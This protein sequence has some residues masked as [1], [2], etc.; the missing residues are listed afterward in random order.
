MTITYKK[1]I[2]IHFSRAIS[3]SKLCFTSSSILRRPKKEEILSDK[4][5]SEP[6]DDEEKKA[7]KSETKDTSDKE[8]DGDEEKKASPVKKDE[9]TSEKEEGKESD[10]EAADEKP[11]KTP[12]I[13]LKCP[14]CLIRCATFGKYSLH[15]QSGRHAS[16]MRRVALKQKAILGQMR[17]VQRKAQRE[18][19]KTTD[20][21][22]PRTSWC[23]LCKLNYKQPKLTHQATQAHKDMK[24]FLMPYCK[25]CK[26][27][28]KSPMIYESHC[29]S[30]DHIKVR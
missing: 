13:K 15:L 14:H 1:M 18:L 11:A 19:E 29:C 26:I 23:Q 30:I 6:E 4:E 3:Y 2:V 21:L 8:E 7:E 17:L 20:D 28:F 24:K 22:A 9:A 12:F 16:A 10:A 27:T 5:D 25:I